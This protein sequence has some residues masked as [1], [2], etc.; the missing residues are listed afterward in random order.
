MTSIVL[1]FN[2]SLKSKVFF[3][4]KIKKRNKT[5]RIMAS[6]LDD[7]EGK[8]DIIKHRKKEENKKW[9][10]LL[11]EWDYGWTAPI[12]WYNIDDS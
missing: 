8:D 2:Y 1:M 10:L 6:Q 5:K 12:D 11:N 4:L 9:K 3:I 7:D